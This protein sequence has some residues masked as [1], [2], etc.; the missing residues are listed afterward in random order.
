M[1][2][3]DKVDFRERKRPEIKRKLNNDKRHNLPVRHN[4]LR[5]ECVPN[6]RA[7]EYNI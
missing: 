6:N 7:S 2:I 1:L 3:A 4:S 5:S